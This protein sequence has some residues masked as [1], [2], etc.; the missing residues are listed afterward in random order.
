MVG[1]IGF[2]RR[3]LRPDVTTAQLVDS[4]GVPSVFKN[5]KPSRLCLVCFSLLHRAAGSEHQVHARR[6]GGFYFNHQIVNT[7]STPQTVTLTNLQSAAI[8]I[9]KI[10]STAQFPVANGCG[11]SL[12]GGATCSIK[13]SFNPSAVT[14]YNA[15]LVIT[16]GSSIPQITIPLT[17]AGINGTAPAAIFVT[18]Q[19]PCILPSHSQ[20][21]STTF[22]SA[23]SS[24]VNWYVNGVHGGNS[25][26]GTITTSGVYT[27]SSVTGTRTIRA[28]SQTNTSVG[29]N[30]LVSVT[31]APSSLV[32]DPYIASIPLGGQLTFKALTC[33]APD[34]NNYN[35]E[36]DGIRAATARLEPSR[37]PGFSATSCR[38][39]P[40]SPH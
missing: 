25:S 14:T 7:P 19:A 5:K 21:F 13:V 6:S 30:S 18:P 11:S 16:N 15:N 17:G 32:L 40:G 12:A 26:V 29:G 39:A 37:Q 33:N 28:V 20:K 4:Q 31:T 34:S 27:A 9:T 10:T 23:P 8:S 1:F 35:F 2:S 36:V 24:A 3:L 22:V 38:Q